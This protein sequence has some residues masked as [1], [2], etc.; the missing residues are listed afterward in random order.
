MIRE[1]HAISRS[2]GRLV[3]LTPVDSQATPRAPTPLDVRRTAVTQV[4]PQ[5]GHLAVPS[6]PPPPAYRREMLS[7][8]PTVR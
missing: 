3:T 1:R 6:R 8:S 5:T 4:R 7:F 2:M